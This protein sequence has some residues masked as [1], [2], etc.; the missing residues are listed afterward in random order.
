[1]QLSWPEHSESTSHTGQDRTCM[2]LDD[3]KAFN[4][5]V[6][7]RGSLWE[8][9]L[10]PSTGQFEWICVSICSVNPDETM[11][12]CF[13]WCPELCDLQS[14]TS[15][16]S[17][18][19]LIAG[20]TPPVCGWSEEPL[21]ERMSVTRRASVACSDVAPA[22]VLHP[23]KPLPAEALLATA[24]KTSMGGKS[25]TPVLKFLVTWLFEPLR[26]YCESLQALLIETPH[27]SVKIVS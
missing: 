15:Q 22:S 20:Q 3:F 25:C 24:A 9:P 17:T 5:E 7:T 4:T 23:P 21:W 16:V 8:W 1:M 12:R 14:Q 27:Y 26:W 6:K 2:I 18:E 13:L 10:Q 11:A 19:V